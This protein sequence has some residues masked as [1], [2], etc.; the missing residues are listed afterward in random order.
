MPQL[1][2]EHGHEVNVTSSGTVRQR[3]ELP[4]R[5]G[6]RRELFVPQ[7][8]RIN[9]PPIP[10]G[11]GIQRNRRASRERQVPIGQIGDRNGGLAEQ[12]ELVSRE[13]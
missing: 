2:H 12:R 9:E 6:V 1:V 11:I 7:W 4:R 3:R 13:C 10:G 5:R 8:R